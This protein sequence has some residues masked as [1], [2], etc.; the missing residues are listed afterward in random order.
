MD[1]VD[2]ATRSRM[3]SS[4]RGRDTLSEIAVRKVLHAAGL[5]FRLHRRDLP[6]SPDIVLPRHRS[7]VF[8]HGCFWH[9][10]SGCRYKTDPASNVDFWRQKFES[11]VRRDRR[12]QR[13]LRNEGWRVFIVWECESRSHAI[14]SALA[15][16]IRRS[17]PTRTQ[18]R[19]ENAR[20]G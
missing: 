13:A 17:A 12:Q 11:N 1:I 7:V 4:I 2:S 10:H 6:G 8:V 18:R 15:K 16:Q 19:R 3:M 9:R 20:R 5:R 14:L